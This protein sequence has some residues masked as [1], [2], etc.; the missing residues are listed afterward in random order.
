M[1]GGSAATPK[2]NDTKAVRSARKVIPKKNQGK[3][4]TPGSEG[5]AANLENPSHGANAEVADTPQSSTEEDVNK[6]KHTPASRQHLTGE[7]G[8]P[9]SGGADFFAW[10]YFDSAGS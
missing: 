10:S 3:A 9:E 4:N 2:P 5:T 6:P 7:I 1:E 8:P